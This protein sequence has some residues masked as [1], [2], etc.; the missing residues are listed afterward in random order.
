V[1][2]NLRPLLAAALLATA[3]A[4]GEA[5]VLVR[6]A[7][8][9]DVETGELRRD[10]AVLVRGELVESV[11]AAGTA[12][13]DAETID[14][15]DLTL[16]PGL[17]DAHTHLVYGPDRLF[18]RFGRHPS[19][20]AAER[21]LVGAAN[22]RATLLAGFTTV[23]DLGACCFADVALARAV[24]DGLVD[25]PEIVPAG[26]VITTTGGSCDQTLAEPW[27][28]DGGPEHGIADG[29]AAILR[30]VRYLLHGARVVKAC[31]DRGNFTEEELRVM[32]DAARR[33]DCS[34]CNAVS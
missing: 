9:L 6:A 4:G 26:H 16:L 28:L 33:R 10:V 18:P 13:A 25:G 17:I 30:A 27:V 12:S 7:R 32:A 31:A 23:R 14:L 5:P 8:L 29:G 1:H 24:A 15:G 11:T 34:R 21:A 2:G 20:G 3:P 22:A 19:V